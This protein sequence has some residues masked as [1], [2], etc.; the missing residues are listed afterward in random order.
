MTE[1]NDPKN[2]DDQKQETKQETHLEGVAVEAQAL[3][4]M[5]RTVID[6]QIATAKQ[7]PRSLTAF[8]KRAREM[9][10]I[11]QETAASCIYSRPVGK[12]GN[13]VIYAQG[14]SI[15]L[16]EIVAATYGNLR[17]G[18]IITEMTPRHV[19]A[20]GMAQDLESNYAIKSEVVESTVKRNGVPYDERQRVVTAKAAQSKAIRDVIFRVIPKSICKPL[21]T[22]AKEIALGEG[23]TLKQRRD[24]LISWIANVQIEPRRIFTALG[25]EGVEEVGI[26]ELI[27]LTGVRTALKDGDITLDEAFPPLEEETKAGVESLKSRLANAKNGK[28]KPE[29]EDPAFEA[30]KQE[31]LKKLKMV[32]LAEDNAKRASE[33]PD[34][35]PKDETEKVNQV[36]GDLL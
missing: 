2:Q 22:L 34:Y 32:Q 1:N 35:P 3:E 18:A 8:L 14:E 19:K 6:S 5:E 9:V 23:E 24:R 25:V 36:Q 4:V 31:Q 27:T 21:A 11:D 7:Y 30:K 16:A 17:V 15:R 20:I 28:D 29:K 12:K 33:I 26:D 13:K 10:S